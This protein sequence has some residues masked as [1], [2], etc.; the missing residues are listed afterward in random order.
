MKKYK[1]LIWLVLALY[2]V[3]VA[4]LL[5]MRL[6][7]EVTDKRGDVVYLLPVS[8]GERYTVRFIHSVARRPV[9]EIYEIAKDCSILRETVYDMMGAGLPT[10]PEEGQTFT[11]KDGKFHI[12]GYDL[13]I[14]VLTYR[15]NKVVADH[16]LFIGG[17]SFKLKK[18]IK[19]PGEPLTFKIKRRSFFDI[20][21]F[22]RKFR[23]Y[24]KDEC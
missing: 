18:W 10:S 8:I 1:Y 13:K 9:D 20:L 24:L 19:A 4:I 5:P 17:E 3:I 12:K 16:E 14:P 22:R 7:L 6:C 23:S 11:V 21:S 15:V 2:G